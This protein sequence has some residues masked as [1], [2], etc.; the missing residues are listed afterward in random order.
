MS[1]RK[2][3]ADGSDGTACEVSSDGLYVVANFRACHPKRSD[4]RLSSRATKS[5]SPLRD[6]SADFLRW[7]GFG[8]FRRDQELTSRTQ[9]WS[10][11]SGRHRG[12]MYHETSETESY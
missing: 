7:G 12:P 11:Q 5:S 1:V 8:V 3:V 4:R 2:E 9:E 10:E 6:V